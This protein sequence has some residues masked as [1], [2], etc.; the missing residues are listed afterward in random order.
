MYFQSA[1]AVLTL[2]KCLQKHVFG[3]FNKN[4]VGLFLQKYSINQLIFGIKI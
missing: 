2:K 1:E 3:I 4:F